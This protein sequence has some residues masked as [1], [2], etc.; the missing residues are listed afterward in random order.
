MNQQKLKNQKQQRRKNRVR[1]K[2]F[3]TAKIPRLSVFKSLKY[4]SVQLID[5]ESG[6]TIASANHKEVDK[7]IKNDKMTTKVNQAFEIGKIIAQKAIDK[8]IKNCVFDKSGY[9]YHGRIKAV[10]DGAR[11]AGL[12]F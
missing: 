2:I 5:D 10:A 6:K 9:K 3:G 4:V 11:E 7:K 12:N 1:A 8:K